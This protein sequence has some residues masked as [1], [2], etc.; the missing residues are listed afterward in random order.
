LQQQNFNSEN[1]EQLLK[2]RFDNL[3]DDTIT[4][5]QFFL[6]LA[7]WRAVNLN[8]QPKILSKRAMEESLY[9]LRCDWCHRDIGG[10]NFQETIS[11]ALKK[12]KL[13]TDTNQ[14][15][16]NQ[17]FHAFT[18]HRSFCPWVNTLDEEPTTWKQVIKYINQDP[19]A[20]SS[21]TPEQAF[22]KINVVLTS[23]KIS[24]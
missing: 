2:A 21:L 1:L 6:A 4:K 23:P 15:P 10:W 16:N 9:I 7:G 17:S 18:Q 22:R 24:R 8:P 12:Y 19:E 3:I 20:K 14:S 5:E 11:P 13:S